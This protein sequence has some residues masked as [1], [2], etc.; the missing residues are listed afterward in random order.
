ML[1]CSHDMAWGA[2]KRCDLLLLYNELIFRIFILFS[3]ACVMIYS[4]VFIEFLLNILIYGPT[5]LWVFQICFCRNFIVV[6]FHLHSFVPGG[7]L[8]VRLNGP[9]L[10]MSSFRL[11]YANQAHLLII[12]RWSENLL[13]ECS[14][15]LRAFV[16]IETLWTVV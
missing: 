16:T 5:W 3:H 9:L 2:I 1:F 8:V 11:L 10:Q 7:A 14:A 6:F 4:I 15:V 13:S 12:T